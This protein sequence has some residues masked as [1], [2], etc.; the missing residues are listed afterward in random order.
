MR[1][2][3]LDGTTARTYQETHPWIIFGLDLREAPG[4]LWLLV[5]EAKA[6]CQ[7]IAGVPLEPEAAEELYK[8]YL[9]KGV[10]ATTSIEGNT[11]SEDQVKQQIEKRLK[12]P[13]S[14]QYLGRE[15][16][17]VLTA[18][19]WVIRALSDD[20][21]LKLTPEQIRK[22][23][24]MILCGL[25]V[26]DHIRP[27]EYRKASVGVAGYRGAPWEDCPYLMERLCEWL[28]TGFDA[29]DEDWKFAYALMKSICAHLYVAW[30]HPFGDGNGRTARMIELLLL[31]Q[32]GVP[33]PAAHLL[34]NHYNKTRDR[35]YSGLAKSSKAKDG[36]IEFVNYA[37]RGFVDGL[38]E[39]VDYIR[40][41]Q[42]GVAWENYV[43]EL[44]RDKDSRASKRQKHL[45]L[46]MPEG[47][48][49]RKLLTRV[50]PRVAMEYA[51]K[52][53]KVLTRDLNAL[54]EMKLVMKTAGGYLPNRQLVLAFLPPRRDER[55]TAG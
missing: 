49:A 11:L 52:G 14:Q 31:V 53:D 12:L 8:V 45:V 50:S 34:S 35:Y 25:E 23:N 54:T 28:N 1:R 39:Q 44:F 19:D 7:H 29:P 3:V 17:N 33:W 6:T 24:G 20:P 46:D 48:T 36:V 18:C 41:Q 5:G 30:I 16:D 43:H 38:Q 37:A 13:S 26:E 21:H 2:R 55:P 10:H 9:S 32:S 42:W 47:V 40:N 27:G 22:L 15:V 51:G 4:R